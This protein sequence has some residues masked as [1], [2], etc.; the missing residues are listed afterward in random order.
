MKEIFFLQIIQTLLIL[1]TTLMLG[2]TLKYTD[3]FELY[4]SGNYLSLRCIKELWYINYYKLKNKSNTEICILYWITL[5]SQADFMLYGND[6]FKH[7]VYICNLTLKFS[8][9]KKKCIVYFTRK[10]IIK[11]IFN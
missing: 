10:Y 1:K 4:P 2:T 7:F 5:L 3:Y 6:E 8:R 11:H 9:W